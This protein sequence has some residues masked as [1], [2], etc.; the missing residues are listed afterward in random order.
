MRGKSK[1]QQQRE[2]KTKTR[3]QKG[4]NNQNFPRFKFYFHR[5]TVDANTYA[6]ISIP[7]LLNQ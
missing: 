4:A 7:I 2:N 1:Q 5:T 6:F 3:Q